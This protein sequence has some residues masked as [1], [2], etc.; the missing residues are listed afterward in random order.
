MS[1]R[2][3]NY[4]NFQMIYVNLNDE[5]EARGCFVPDI[6]VLQPNEKTA[7]VSLLQCRGDIIADADGV[8]AAMDPRFAA[9]TKEY[10]THLNQSQPDLAATPEY[11]MP[12]GAVSFA[13]E[14]EHLPSEGCIWVFGCES[15]TPEKLTVLM[16]SNSHVEWIVDD[17]T[18]QNP[19][20]RFLDPIL[21][22]FRIRRACSG[23]LATAISVQF[24]ATQMGGDFGERVEADNLI[25][26]AKRYYLRKENSI[27]LLPLICS[28]VFEFN[29]LELCERATWSYLIVH[30]QMTPKPF[31]RKFCQY[32]DL[33]F[34]E[35]YGEKYEF[36]CLNWAAGTTMNGNGLVV[37]S[38]GSA[39]YLKPPK[40][41]QESAGNF[42]YL[43]PHQT[44]DKIQD[45]HAMGLYL[46]FCE[47]RRIAAYYFF[48]KEGVFEFMVSK[49][50]QDLAPAPAQKHRSGATANRTL[51]FEENS[52]SWVGSSSSIDDG[53]SGFASNYDSKT[54]SVVSL[55]P[56]ERERL[57]SISCGHIDSRQWHYCR[58]MRGF[59]IAEHEEFPGGVTVMLRQEQ[60]EKIEEELSKI[61]VINGE[62]LPRMNVFDFPF[63]DLVRID[64]GLALT[65]E[66]G[67]HS[68]IH[69]DEKGNMNAIV[70]YLGEITAA[71]AEMKYNQLKK[72]VPD[73]RVLSFYRLGGDIRL[74]SDSLQSI[75]SAEDFP[76]AIIA[77]DNA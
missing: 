39:Y 2:A 28:D 59:Q 19:A 43:E 62:I 30:V 64:L 5:L 7:K 29:H 18:L 65:V 71:R 72:C 76:D 60:S 63:S 13:I 17:A 34:D 70:M 45:N 46:K 14:S 40:F 11:S 73:D 68:N 25:C 9:A 10:I 69:S 4:K 36:I 67:R 1:Q 47:K 50:S 44:D 31:Y 56:V 6:N 51:F 66:S 74:V 53:V 26:G 27:A 24:K 37:D 41:N 3:N 22:I 32:R 54:G 15:I 61:S 42:C 55:D 21:I 8:S 57:V 16:G 20:K 58:K 33:I 35:S 38:S 77:E 48:A 52:I 23:E 75:N 49:V 12:W